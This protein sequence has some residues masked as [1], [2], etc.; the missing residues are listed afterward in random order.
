M[1]AADKTAHPPQGPKKAF[2]LAAGRGER[3]RPLTDTCPKPLLNVGGM[4]MLDR[5]LDALA[6]AGVEEAIVNV[7][8]LGEMI[9]EHLKKR[10][11][12]GKAPRITI[13]REDE[14]LDTGGGVKK[15]LAFFGDEPFYVLNADVVW[16]D[17]AEST[18]SAMARAWDAARMD[19][20][21]L[22]HTTTDLPGYA[23]RG[24]YYL[25]EG[26]DQPVFGKKAD[27]P[28]NFIFA[29]PRIVHPRLFKDAPEGAFS[30]LQ[31]FHKAEAAGRLFAHRHDG[32]W[33]HVG[34]PEALEKTNQILS[35]NGADR[36]RPRQHA[37]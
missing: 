22:L 8:Y 13:S 23:G 12:A 10:E 27:A 16:T 37:P 18:L 17:G 36:D 24:D 15:A 34:T 31:L 28:A 14:M 20:L 29:G 3:M 25:A 7:C 32:D 5:A 35:A 6:A 33:H 4:S 19:L 26:S 21:L 11:A 1:A 30:F 9:A 2:V